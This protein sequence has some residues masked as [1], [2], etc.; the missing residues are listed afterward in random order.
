MRPPVVPALVIVWPVVLILVVLLVLAGC[1]G[2]GITREQSDERAIVL[3]MLTY[4][5]GRA[6]ALVETACDREAKAWL[7][8][9]QLDTIQ[10]DVHTR[11]WPEIRRQWA[12]D[13]EIDWARVA[14]LLEYMV[15]FIP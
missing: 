10:Q 8:C 2:L 5:Y 12:T 1:A 13:Q 15:R 9:N 3:S 11:I 7:I 4:Q 14:E 6:E